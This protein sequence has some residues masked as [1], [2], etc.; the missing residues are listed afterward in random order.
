MPSIR[1]ATREDIPA[2]FD[3]RTSVRE[4]SATRWQ[5]EQLGI[6]E[7]T[8]FEAISTEG[9]GWIA[10][11]HGYAVGF[12]IAELREGSVFALYVRPEYEGRGY[13]RELLTAAVEW[14][15]SKGFHRVWLAVGTDTRAH[16]FYLKHGWIPTGRIEPNG[17][18][19]LELKSRFAV[20]VRQMAEAEMESVVK[21]W[22]AAKKHAYSYLPLEQA[23][24]LEEDAAFF[25]QNICSRCELW[26]AERDGQVQGFLALDGSY[27]DRIY[28]S[29]EVQQTGIGSAL[30]HH[31]K[32]LSPSGLE[33][34]THQKNLAA[35]RFYQKHGFRP[36][37]FGI[38]PAPESEPD[39][40]YH[41]R[42]ERK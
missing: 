38:S 20:R 42:P 26:I 39:V 9:H 7:E 30:I 5:L 21:L 15:F 32:K 14:L 4:N 27:I 16:R 19:E 6:N 28:V 1:D 31:A 29:P 18:V 10:E 8:V 40:E 41:W 22:H 34:H 2:I 13:G 33:L 24:T 23:R 3:I 36:V 11:D 25:T 17:D 35:C 12:S 37:R